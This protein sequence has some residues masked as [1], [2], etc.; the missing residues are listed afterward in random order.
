[1]QNSTLPID[2]VLGQLSEA[3]RHQQTIILQAEP[4]AGKTT[5]V[6]LALMEQPYIEGKILL[7]EP[8]RIAARAAALYMAQ[9][10]EEEIGQR[11]GYSIRFEQH[12]S[13][14][15]RIE[16]ITEGLLARRLM[17]DPELSDVS[18][19]IF[20]EFHERSIHTDLALALCREVAAVRDQ[21][22]RLLLMSATIDTEQLSRQLENAPVITSPGRAFPVEVIRADRPI[23]GHQLI[24]ELVKRCKQTLGLAGDVLVFLPGRSEIRRLD[25][26]LGEAFGNQPELNI[27]PLYSGVDERI[28]KD[29]FTPPAQG[30]KRFI[31]ATS[32]AQTSI[33]LPGVTCVIDSGLERRPKYS[34]R[35]DLTRLSTEKVSAATAAQ[36]AGRAGRIQAGICYQLW[37]EEQHR[38]LSDNDRP[39]ITELDLS[40]TLLVLLN[41]G[42]QRIDD[43]SWIDPPSATGWQRALEGLEALD[44]IE[45]RSERAILTQ[46]G[47]R[48]CQIP[49]SVRTARLVVEA[50]DLGAQALGARLAAITSEPA[51]HA[52]T[53]ITVQLVQ[54]SRRP[55]IARLV[56]RFEQLIPSKGGGNLEPNRL[57]FAAYG[58]RV[59]KCVDPSSGR[60]KLMSG[61]SVRLDPTDPLCRRD[62]L[63]CI[64]LGGREDQADLRLTLAAP[65]SLE[66][67]RSYLKTQITH[68]SLTRWEGEALRAV[69]VERL[70]TLELTRTPLAYPTGPDLAFAWC[71]RIKKEGLSLLPHWN[72]VMPW[73]ARVRYLEQHKAL[74]PES[75]DIPPIDDASLLERIEEWL[76]LALEN[77]NRIADLEKIELKTQLLAILPW[78]IDQWLER[79]A[80]ERFLAPSGRWVKI[81]YQTEIPSIAIKLQE[82]F[83]TDQ[84]PKTGLGLPIRVELLSP[85]GRPLAV[86]TDLRHFWSQTYAQVRKENRGRYAKHPWPEDPM[87]STAS[88]LTN[89]A[90]RRKETD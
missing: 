82:M 77:A 33:T 47:K 48:M 44:A 28:L 43:L 61:T 22:L 31:L 17:Q 59:A 45:W 50:Q 14:Q 79:Y 65:V 69:K 38:Q 86:T 2:S 58:D 21:P 72:S 42:V 37:S 67:I 64:E 19:V 84:S 30:H 11:I 55:N 26:K 35:L 85:A 46:I 49:A 83:G 71:E 90:L 7:L 25:E 81:D 63:I 29:L 89:A 70:G 12:V 51:A 40:E 68:E 27:V 76:G 13:A 1:M 62:Y 53:D 41:W 87:S 75:L 36:R 88:H 57:L 16:V 39:Q 66:E 56:K 80:A 9:S 32:I 3:F 8:R 18:V 74:A 54:M 73:L 52:E 34:P 6:P 24:D 23:Q 10:L 20:D 78:Q 5:R 15:T 4:G 60:F